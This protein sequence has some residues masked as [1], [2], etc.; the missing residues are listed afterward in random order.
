MN[1]MKRLV[2]LAAAALLLLTGCDLLDKRPGIT[3]EWRMMEKSAVGTTVNLYAWGGDAGANRWF[4]ETLKP[5][6]ADTY[7]ITLNRVPMN[8]DEIF[9]LLAADQELKRSSGD[10]DLLWISGRNL[11]YAQTSGYLF[12]PYTDRLPNVNLYLSPKDPEL[13]ADRGVAIEGYAAPLGR[14]QLGLFYNEDVLYDP[15]TDLNSLMAAVKANPGTF[16]YPRPEDPAG[17]AF[18]Q[19]VIIGSVGEET[20]SK[21][22]PS[23][24]AVAAAIRPGLDYLKAL[25]P[26]LWQEGAVYPANEAELDRLFAN[27]TLAMAMSWDHNHATRLLAEDRYNPGAKPFTLASG[28]VGNTHYLSIPFNAANKSGAMVVVNAALDVPM[29]AS[30]LRPADWGD[31]PVLDLGLL[32]AESVRTLKKSIS[33]KT[34]PKLEDLAGHRLPQLSPSLEAIITELWYEQIAP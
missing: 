11:E 19:S 25:E 5:Y 23:K 18:I 7:K 13:L 24:E 4:D 12:G 9:E 10:M 17:M 2:A 27:G 33:K 1:R 22:P 28:T 20:V 26:Y 32:P 29:Q 15:P 34:S 21:L 3:R 30:K 8:Y 31:L 14:R 6:L 16:T